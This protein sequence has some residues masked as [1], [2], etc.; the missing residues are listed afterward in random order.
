MIPKK[1]KKADLENKRVI[2]FQ[3]GLIISLAIALLAFEWVTGTPEERMIFRP[4]SD[5]PEDDLL[6]N[7]FREK[8]IP[9]VM[10]PHDYFTFDI[11]DNDEDLIAEATDFSA[12]I[13]PWEPYNIQYEPEEP[14]DDIPFINVSEKPTFMGGDFSNFVKYIQSTVVYQKE[15]IDM[16][17]QGKVFAE[18]IINKKGYVENIRIVR[19]VDP[20]LD[21]EV[22]KALKSSPRWKPGKQ[23]DIPVKV[24]CTIPV[25]FKISN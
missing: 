11:K 4:V 5:D 10:K 13:A 20:L 7:T 15:A 18:F 19:G 25:L 23:R 3:I 17:I 14:D 1:S 6:L 22:V 9:P 21:N 24:I 8:E 12:E 16:G 2:F